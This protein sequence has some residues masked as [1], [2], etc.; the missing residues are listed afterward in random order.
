MTVHPP[1]VAL[2]LRVT[3]GDIDPNKTCHRSFPN[4]RSRPSAFANAGVAGRSGG[5]REFRMCVC[6]WYKY[7]VKK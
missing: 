4:S 1:P 7:L 3:N 6:V 5:R 2:P